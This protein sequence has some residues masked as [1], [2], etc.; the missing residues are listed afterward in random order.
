[1]TLPPRF[2]WMLFKRRLPVMLALFLI[3]SGLAVFTALQLPPTY[4][5]SARLQVDP[6]QIPDE[7]V[8]SMVQTEAAEQLQLIEE[9]LMTRANLIDIAQK[10]QVFEEMSSMNPDKIVQRMVESTSIFRSGGRGQAT[11]M[12]VAFEASNGQVAANVINDY[13]TL[14]LDAN[15][16]FRRE[17]A[18][19]TLVFFEQEADRLAAEIDAQS[20]RIIAFKNEN[21]EALPEDLLYRQERQSTLQ[22]R[23]GR[24]EQESASIVSQ[25]SEMIAVFEATG[26]LGHNARRELSPE[27]M[28]LQELEVQLAEA[29]TIYSETNPRVIQLRG[30]IEQLERAIS[31]EGPRNR[32]EG[33]ESEPTFLDITLAEMDSRVEEIDLEIV[34][35]NEELEGLARAIAATATNSITLERFERD[36]DGARTRYNSVLANLDQAR[37]AERIEINAQGQR[38]SLIEGASV[39]QEPSGPPRK[40]IAAMGGAVGIG[41]AL[42]YFMLLELL[43][44]KVRHPAE[45]QLHFEI[46]PLGV[47]PYL[48]SRGEKWRRRLLPLGALALAMVVVPAALYYVHNE[49]MPLEIL[50]NRVLVQVGLA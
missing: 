35:V 37:M 12:S 43:N 19:N 26:R 18:E 11:L 17:R 42:A 2:Y 40:K 15:S 28:R 21:V 36:V 8:R 47:I 22:E 32:Q 14:I 27:E 49:Y 46:V 23:L 6:Q 33:A 20:N 48:E 30:Q 34:R 45:L 39:P 24:L 9:Q 50:V 16:S 4:Q 38:I 29:L 13:V 10:Y 41:L 25:R 1:M 44:Q 3:C 31:G 5:S 7:M